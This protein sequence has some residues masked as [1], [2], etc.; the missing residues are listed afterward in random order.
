MKRFF[1][2]S[3]LMFRTK[4]RKPLSQ[5]LLT[6]LTA[7]SLAGCAG[8]VNSSSTS[9]TLYNSTASINNYDRKLNTVNY[10][11]R[12]AYNDLW[13][14][15]RA[16]LGNEVEQNNPRIDYYVR[17]FS[18]HPAYFKKL[19]ERSRPY[20]YYIMQQV[21]KR[22]MP[23]EFALVP[24]VESAFDPFA[25]SYGL[26]SGLWQITPSTGKYYEIKQDWWFDGRRDIV[27]ATNFSLNYFQQL[28]NEFN[29]W[30]L[31]L[32][33]YNAGNGT[34][35]RAIQYNLARKQS[36]SY[37]DLRLPKQTENY[38]PKLLAVAKIIQQP[39]RYGIKLPPIPNRPFFTLV[40]IKSQIDL[41]RAAN[42]ADI[43]LKDLR[44]LNPGYNR[45]ATDPSGPHSLLIPTE[46]A[47]H[48]ELKLTNLSNSE[49]IGWQRYYVHSNNTLSS[50]AKVFNTSSDVIKKV[51]HLENNN[52]YVGEDLLIP[53]P[54]DDRVGM[55][56]TQKALAL[57]Q[58]KNIISN[59]QGK[60]RHTYTVKPGD[61]LW[62]IA[63]LHN[64]TLQQLLTWNHLTNKSQV[65][66]GQKLLLWIGH[67]NLIK[68]TYTVKQGD[69]FWTIAQHMH[70]SVD[71]LLAW[72]NLDSN[73]II[74]PEQQLIIWKKPSLSVL[75]AGLTHSN[76]VIRRVYYT[77][78]KGESMKK[79][80][81]KFK[82][83][84]YQITN[85]NTLH[86]THITPGQK[87]TLF[88]DVTRAE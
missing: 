32:A 75:R 82:V 25:Y 69:N 80:A 84:T 81:S 42:M 22:Q 13:Q 45:W 1:I 48:F 35:G 2:F 11:N 71:Q 9:S 88:V 87:L 5:C 17:W 26:A 33:A 64:M 52:I 6:V 55:N 53:Q 21:E 59:K 31:A 18:K 16:Q 38:V 50:I 79:I 8:V 43:S 3:F 10:N 51:N 15:V 49:R 30:E 63:K 20:L 58:S 72:N 27:T 47:K 39:A 74:R 57:A 62:L 23:S 29:S 65:K 73:A 66:P 54:T 34:V 4:D 44:Q 86:S 12:I 85:W 41:K 7:T 68:H 61:N 77:V 60:L 46:K 83:A 36:I 37:W 78:R 28:H 76:S 24:F 14:R 67:N 56:H 40:N 70:T 19:M